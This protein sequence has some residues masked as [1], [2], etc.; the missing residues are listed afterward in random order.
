M[1]NYGD[2]T[3][4]IRLSYGSDA[5]FLNCEDW[6]YD[7][8]DKSATNIDYPARGH[9]G[10]TLNTEVVVIKI[11]GVYV[12]TEAEWN[13]LKAQI[14]AAQEAASVTIRIQISSTPT[15]ELYDGGAGKD[16][17]PVLIKATK[18]RK[19]KFKGDTTVY[20][21]KQITLTQSGAL[22]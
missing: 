13:V 2:I 4:W 19:K 11:T 3:A 14:K 1:A 21:I 17:M 12:L 9:Y 7:N 22:A 8:T 18:G 20:I 5:L 6:E 15:Y 10:Y 16:E